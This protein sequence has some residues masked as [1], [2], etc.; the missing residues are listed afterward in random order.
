MVAV[1]QI[2]NSDLLGQVITIP[3]YMQNM[4]LEIFIRPAILT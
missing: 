4:Q 2:I 3:A 1:K